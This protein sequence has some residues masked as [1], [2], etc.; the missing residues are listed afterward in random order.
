V[1]T[2]SLIVQ[3]EVR[4]KAILILFARRYT[5]TLVI[6]RG[7]IT[8][9][10]RRKLVPLIVSTIILSASAF[11]Q[12]PA[13]G[14]AR[15]PAH[16]DEERGEAAQKSPAARSNQTSTARDDRGGWVAVYVGGART[17]DTGCSA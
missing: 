9:I 15:L 7:V 4:P 5:L 1:S 2:A 3:P 16:G 17:D 11:A 10:C 6:A 12:D 8:V 13:Q 14:S